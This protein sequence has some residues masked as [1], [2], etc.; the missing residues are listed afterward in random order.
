M[1][2][3]RDASLRGSRTTLPPHGILA[4]G[5]DDKVYPPNTVATILDALQREGIPEGSSLKGAQLAP[6]A[7][8]SYRTKVSLNQVLQ[9]CRNAAKLSRDPHFAFHAG[10]RFH[11]STFGMYG[12]ALLSCTSHRLAVSI[13]TRYQLLATPLVELSFREE[14]GRGIWSFVPRLQPSEPSG[15][16]R[17]VIP[18]TLGILL[19][20]QRE[21]LGTSFAPSEVHVPLAAHGEAAFYEQMLGCRVRF[22]CPQS[23]FIFP[24]AWLDRPKDL[25]NALAQ[26]ETVKL[27]DE[28]MEQLRLRAGIAGQVREFLL[29]GHMRPTR[30]PAVA[31]HLHMT[32]RTLRRKLRE[33]RTSFRKLV[34]EL[35]MHLALKYLRD[36]DLTIQEIAHAVG[37]SEDASFRH[38]FRRWSKVP[39]RRFRARMQQRARAPEVIEPPGRR[40]GW[41]IR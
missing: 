29:E 36:T 30:C 23:E 2:A 3:P 14:H 9:V 8:H 33:E 1:I 15:V 4:V 32:E 20:V 11:V 37:F 38:A 40:P 26:Q 39:P 22:D 41:P 18:L 31:K 12:F 21:L 13:A 7:L 5:I 27:C 16:A 35:R 24:A 34:D 10:L 17:F 25:G 6:R 28:L 19:S